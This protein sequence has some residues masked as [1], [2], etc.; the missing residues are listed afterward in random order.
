M[1]SITYSIFYC[2][3]YICVAVHR[4]IL[5]IH[6]IYKHILLLLHCIS[7]KQHAG[8]SFQNAWLISVFGEYSL[9]L[10]VK[11]H[12]YIIYAYFRFQRSFFSRHGAIKTT[13]SQTCKSLRATTETKCSLRGILPARVAGWAALIKRDFENTIREGVH[14]A[15]TGFSCPWSWKKKKKK[16]DR[17]LTF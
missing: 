1:K 8:T 10:C 7:K 15:D 6:I 17:I 13:S 16:K 12:T 5:L 9:F 2:K 4:I 11:T 14:H 3:T